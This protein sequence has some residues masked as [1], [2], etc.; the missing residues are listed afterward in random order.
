MMIKVH[1]PELEALISERMKTGTFEEIEDLLI[2]ALKASPTPAKNED[3]P[4]TGADLVAAVQ[5]APHKG[6]DFQ[7]R[8]AIDEGDASGIA[9]GD[10]F[11]RV[12]K[13]LNLSTTP[14]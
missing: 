4:R 14:R 9:D 3:A 10:I 8:A 2:Q 1:K 7:L 12:R 13:Q 5:A 6:I 11:A